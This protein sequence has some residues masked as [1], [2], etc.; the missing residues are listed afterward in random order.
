MCFFMLYRVVI[1]S[2]YSYFQVRFS[3]TESGPVFRMPPPCSVVIQVGVPSR[4]FKRFCL[5]VNVT[6]SC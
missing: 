5:S 6:R 3:F 2:S 1:V 4:L